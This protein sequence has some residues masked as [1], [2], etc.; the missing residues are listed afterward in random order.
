MG[1]G[2]IV[3]AIQG[4]SEFIRYK[5]FEDEMMRRLARVCIR[6][7]IDIEDCPQLLCDLLNEKGGK[8]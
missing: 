6:H 5:R 2:I 3:I 4:I 1:F 7:S 8:R